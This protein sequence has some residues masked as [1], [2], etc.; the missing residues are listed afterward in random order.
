[1]RP[2]SVIEQMKR[3]NLLT[4]LMCAWLRTRLSRLSR[5][6][7]LVKN[8]HWSSL[9][10]WKCL[11]FLLCQ[12]RPPCRKC[13]NFCKMRVCSRWR[14]LG[15]FRLRFRYRSE[16]FLR[17]MLH[18]IDSSSWVKVMRIKSYFSCLPTVNSSAGKKAWKRWRARKKDLR[19]PT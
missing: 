14:R 12:G 1:M 9:S 11:M 7:G 19:W 8:S 5:S 15:V 4:N 17:L 16:W 10:L 13:T 3:P 6:F 2:T 18:L